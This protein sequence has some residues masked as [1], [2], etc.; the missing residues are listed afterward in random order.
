[1]VGYLPS[2]VPIYPELTSEAFLDYL[3]RISR[4]TISPTR[5]ESLLRRFD[6]SALDQR[7]KLRDLSHGMKRKLGIVQALMTDAPVLILDEPTSG[8]DP[9]VIE[10][11]CETI[12]ELKRGGVTTV[13]LSSH[14][15][16]EVE[17]LCDRVGLIRHGQLID[18]PTLDNLRA[19][20]SRVVVVEF[21][22]PVDPPQGL[23]NTRILVRD[24]RRWVIEVQGSMGALVAA[25]AGLPVADL[26]VADSPLSAFVRGEHDGDVVH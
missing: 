11:F 18:T 23:P 10:A 26:R 13:F 19:R 5:L 9:L 24:A 1:M 14:V 8:L 25:L 16:S 2:E 6:I 20:G 4:K 15:L 17:R 12:A 22:E 3:A 7:R 21:R